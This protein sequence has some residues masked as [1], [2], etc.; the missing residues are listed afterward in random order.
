MIRGFTNDVH[1]AMEIDNLLS[2]SRRINNALCL[3]IREKHPAVEIKPEL[4]SG[5]EW[6][7]EQFTPGINSAWVS[8]LSV[9]FYVSNG[10][11]SFLG[12]VPAADL[13]QK[14]VEVEHDEHTDGE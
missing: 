4:L 5:F 11:E 10:Q 1:A 2:G 14:M 6:D 7:Y 3:M 8:G 13:V 9:Q 12:R